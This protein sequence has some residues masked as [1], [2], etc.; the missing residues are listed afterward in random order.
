MLHAS[1][2]LSARVTGSPGACAG[3]F[4]YQ[5]D[6]QES[7]IEILTS[8]ETG[9][10]HATNQPGGDAGAT[11]VVGIPASNSASG[12]SNG[13][14]SDWNEYRLDWVP[15]SSTWYVNGQLVDTKTVNVPTVGMLFSIN[16]WSNGGEWTGSMP[17]GNAA[18]LDVRWIEMVYNQTS[19]AGTGASGQTCTVGNGPNAVS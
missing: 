9:V 16:L 18:R 5:S 11:K 1:I 6:S 15:G 7:D 13:T 19:D 8:G 14:W 17:V 2:R 3:L 12:S 4:L 10:F